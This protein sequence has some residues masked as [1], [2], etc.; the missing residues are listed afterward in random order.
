MAI[1]DAFQGT[2]GYV[3]MLI[4]GYCG[5]VV[6]GLRF[7]VQ[8]IATERRRQVTVPLAFWYLSLVGTVLLLSWAIYRGDPVL[9]PG[10][11]LNI[12]IYLRNLYFA[13]KPRAAAAEA[14]PSGQ[15]TS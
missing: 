9:I 8:W 6:F 14:D 15:Q 7:I 4:L 2:T 5:Q 12:I 11:C 1:I 10:F 3:I 13:R